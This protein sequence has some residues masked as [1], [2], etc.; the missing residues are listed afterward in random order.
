[1]A[2]MAIVGN[3]IVPN[4]NSGGGFSIG[5]IGSDSDTDFLSQ[6][7]MDSVGSSGTMN[8][9]DVPTSCSTPTSFMSSQVRNAQHLQRSLSTQPQRTQGQ[10]PT[11]RPGNL[12]QYNQRSSSLD[13]GQMQQ[14]GMSQGQKS[15]AIAHSPGAASVRNGNFTFPAQRG[16]MYNRRSPAA[17]PIQQGFNTPF[18]RTP[19]PMLSPSPGR[20]L[21][22]Y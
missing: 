14:T 3:N 9:S 6:W 7:D 21:Y 5:G 19:S 8:I 17:S 18:P 1:M 13:Q 4:L 2:N 16:V 20:L 22:S 12:A 15:P 10:L 11:K